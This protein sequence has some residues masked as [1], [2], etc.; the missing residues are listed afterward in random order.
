MDF[1][2]KNPKRPSAEDV[3]DKIA[4]QMTSQ[5]YYES[6]ISP[7]KSITLHTAKIDGRWFI[8]LYKNKGCEMFQSVLF[9]IYEAQWVVD[10]LI[11]MYEKLISECPRDEIEVSFI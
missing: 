2:W 3:A 4:Q 10:R 5:E 9:S 8:G 6:G 1:M 11:R 7:I